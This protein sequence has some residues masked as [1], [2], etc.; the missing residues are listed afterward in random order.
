MRSRE[1]QV[2]VFCSMTYVPNNF[3]FSSRHSSTLKFTFGYNEDLVIFLKK[4]KLLRI[5]G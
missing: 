3:C 2:T 5:E 4:K 1:V